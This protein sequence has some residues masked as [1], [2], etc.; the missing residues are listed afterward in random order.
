MLER[1]LRRFMK[2]LRKTHMRS[3]GVLSHIE[4]PRRAD[5]RADKYLMAVFVH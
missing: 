1:P 4:H 3:F 5:R 2:A